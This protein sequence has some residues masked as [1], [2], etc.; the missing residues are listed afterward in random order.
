MHERNDFTKWIRF[1]RLGILAAVALTLASEG[2]ASAFCR[3]RTVSPDPSR[4]PS[5][6]GKCT[7]EGV[8]LFWRNACVG[9]SIDT[10]VSRQLSFD[11]VADI[12][13][14]SFSRWTGASCAGADSESRVSIDVRDLGPA[15]CQKV[16]TDLDG[17]N[18]NTILFR[19]ESWLNR[20]GSP[21]DSDKLAVTTLSFNRETGEVFGADMELSLIHISEPTRPY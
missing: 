14:N 15:V 21:R 20:D 8:P 17:P 10:R 4:D 2:D 7:E 13:A 5:L 11:V 1:R 19:D 9:Y 16:E 6:T 12:V 3:S 18:V